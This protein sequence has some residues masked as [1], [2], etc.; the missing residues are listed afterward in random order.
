[1]VLLLGSDIFV[2]DSGILVST[3]GSGMFVSKVGSIIVGSIIDVEG[4]VLGAVVG[5]VV[6]VDGVS[7]RLQ[8]QA[9]R[10]AA[11]TNPRAKVNIFLIYPPVIVKITKVVLPQ[12]MYLHWKKKPL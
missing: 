7:L 2:V 12:L 4:L 5:V 11:I 9:A 10:E 8:P 1:M 3:L 6:G